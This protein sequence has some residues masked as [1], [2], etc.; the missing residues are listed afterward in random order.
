MKKL[1]LSLAL[2]AGGS[3]VVAPAVVSAK[4]CCDKCDSCSCCNREEAKQDTA[5]S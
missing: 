4:S 2:F 1:L 3:I 5:Q